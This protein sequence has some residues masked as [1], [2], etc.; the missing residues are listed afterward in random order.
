MDCDK[1]TT[2][3]VFRKGPVKLGVAGRIKILQMLRDYFIA[4]DYLGDS[5]DSLD[6]YM[7]IEFMPKLVECLQEHGCLVNDH[8][9]GPIIIGK[10]E[11]LA[12]CGQNNYQI[13]CDTTLL[14]VSRNYAAIGSGSE[15]AL[16]AMYNETE[17]A[18]IM[19]QGIETGD[20]IKT[21]INTAIAFDEG[22]G[23][24]VCII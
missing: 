7:T 22:C 9:S 6:I 13:H 3:K 5:E 2:P 18:K 16:G 1:L 19:G 17:R 10:S 12:V 11:I 23:G 14:K 20:F 21:A 8:E 15:Y 24:P 4:P